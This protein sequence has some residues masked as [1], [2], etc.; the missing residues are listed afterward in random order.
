MVPFV[1]LTVITIV[2]NL[3]NNEILVQQMFSRHDDHSLIMIHS[4]VRRFYNTLGVTP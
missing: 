2:Q 1:T 4:H 3:K